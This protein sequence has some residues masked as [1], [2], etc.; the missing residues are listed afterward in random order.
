MVGGE[1]PKSSLASSHIAPGRG[2]S[3]FHGAGVEVQGPHMVS[4][5]TVNGGPV[6]LRKSKS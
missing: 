5:F 6:T 3:N 1:S 2:M 4:T